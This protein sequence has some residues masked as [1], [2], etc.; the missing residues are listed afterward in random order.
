M[1]SNLIIWIT[2]IMLNFL[3]FGSYL[4]EINSL[5][6]KHHYDLDLLMQ[7]IKIALEAPGSRISRIY[8]L[9]YITL[10][11]NKI[12]V[13]ERL[14]YYQFLFPQINNTIYIPI[15]INGSIVLRGVVKITIYS[16]SNNGK[17]WVVVK[18]T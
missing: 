4:M 5:L 11:E 13:D 1:K 8:F 15:K 12:I 17:V 16:Y 18:K 9:P 3:L 6:N 10:R 2:F 7:D 14:A